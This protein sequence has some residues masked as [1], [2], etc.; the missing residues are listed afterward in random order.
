M[1]R[2]RAVAALVAV[3][4]VLVVSG[5]GG[6]ERREPAGASPTPTPDRPAPAY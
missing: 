6:D 1:S 4:A 3:G 2:L 5:C